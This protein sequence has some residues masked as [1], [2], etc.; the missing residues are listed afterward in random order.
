MAIFNLYVKMNIY[1][2]AT[3][4][5][6]DWNRCGSE[7]EDSCLSLK[8]GMISLRLFISCEVDFCFF[9]WL[10]SSYTVVWITYMNN[11]YVICIFIFKLLYI[12][13]RHDVDIAFVTL[14]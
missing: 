14:S 4:I 6:L 8:L 2:A 12:R 5:M 3:V 13:C 9:L 1:G 7:K 10:S 11:G